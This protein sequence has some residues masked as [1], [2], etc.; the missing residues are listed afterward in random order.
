MLSDIDP[1]IRSMAVADILEAMLRLHDGH[2]SNTAKT[3]GI[4]RQRMDY[5]IE[6]GDKVEDIIEALENARR[7]LGLSKSAL[8][9][10]LTG[11]K[12]FARKL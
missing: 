3:L 1:R 12:K 9:D 4:S 11:A 8:W 10:I 6:S 7:H 5:L 2:R